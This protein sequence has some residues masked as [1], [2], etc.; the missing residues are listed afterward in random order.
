M[1]ITMNTEDASPAR[2]RGRSEAKRTAMLSAAE[3]LFLADGYERASVDAIAAAAGVSKR[4]IYDHFGDK[5]NLFSAV[6]A[7]VTSKVMDTLQVAIE[8]ELPEGCDPGPSLLSFVRRVATVTFSSSEYVLFRRLLAAS[9]PVRTSVMRSQ[10]DPAILLA[11]R[12][13]DFGRSGTLVVPNPRRATDH[14]VALTLHLAIDALETEDADPSAID[15][16][17]IDG[18]AAFL[19][20]YAPARMPRRTGD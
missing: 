20:A 12:M 4:T 13:A 5:E 9:G 1:V 6:V 17:L 10:D 11:T 15:E 19:R 8:E 18:I 14:V 7:S 16:I 3:S 2:R